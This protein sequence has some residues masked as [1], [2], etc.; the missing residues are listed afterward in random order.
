LTFA[1]EVDVERKLDES[2]PANQAL[3][4]TAAMLVPES[5]LSHSA[6]RTLLSLVVRQHAS[7]LR[8]TTHLRE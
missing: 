8:F 1:A 3:Q 4:Q 7:T 6:G 5:S 2:S